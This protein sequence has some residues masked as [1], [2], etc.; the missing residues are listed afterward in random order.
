MAIRKLKH[1]VFVPFG[2]GT[3]K[4]PR[5]LALLQIALHDLQASG[6]IGD[7]YADEDLSESLGN[8]DEWLT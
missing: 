2:D 4:L 6:Y 5:D 8:I 7:L 1:D 3:L